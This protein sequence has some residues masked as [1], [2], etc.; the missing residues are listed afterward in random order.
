MITKKTVTT[1]GTGAHVVLPKEIAGHDVIIIYDSDFEDFRDLVRSSYVFSKL[2]DSQIQ[3]TRKEFKMMKDEIIPRIA[4]IERTL[5]SLFD[6]N[7]KSN[8]NTSA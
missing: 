7:K 2:A 5:A 8:G 3:E 6:S 4:Y 1:Y